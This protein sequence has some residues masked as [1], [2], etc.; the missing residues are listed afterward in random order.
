MKMK[1]PKLENLKI[2][3]LASSEA[4]FKNYEKKNAKI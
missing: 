4:Y 3:K 2:Q 1:H